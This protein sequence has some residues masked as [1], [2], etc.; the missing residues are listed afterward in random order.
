MIPALQ[1]AVEFPATIANIPPT[2][3]TKQIAMVTLLAVVVSL[4]AWADDAKPVQ[5]DKAKTGSAAGGAGSEFKNEKEKLSY[6]IGLDSGNRLRQSEIEVDPD[7]VLRGLK[8]GTAGGKGLLT[9][10]D[11]RE[12]FTKLR[13]EVMARQ[14]EKQRQLGEKNR[15]EGEAFLAA[16]KD[17]PGVITLPSGLQYQVLTEGDG[18]TPKPE[19]RVTVNYRGTLVD[20]TEFDRSP[21]NQ[22]AT[23]AANGVIRGWTEALTH[24]KTGAKWKL[25]IPSDLAYGLMGFPQRQIGPNT[26]LIFEVELVS[27]ESAPPPPAATANPHPPLTSDIIKVPSLDEMKKGAK[28]ETIKAEDVEKL[29]KQQQEQQERKDKENK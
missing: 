12:I 19:D 15:K 16:N 20:G 13:Q 9:D 18:Q 22:P 25:F 17:K 10:Q 24:M 4:A 27:V 3:N 8:D 1:K 6:A 21:T 11:L 7:M 29:Q 5:T 28:I 2:M 14:H 23:F 26:A